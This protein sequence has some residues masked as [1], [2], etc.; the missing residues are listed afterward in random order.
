[1]AS[2]FL[3]KFLQQPYL[4]LRTIN[5][6]A[7]ITKSSLSGVYLRVCLF[8]EVIL[9]LLFNFLMYYVCLFFFFQPRSRYME[10]PGPGI[11]SEW[12]RFCSCSNA[13]SWTH[14]TELGI[15]PAMPQRPARSWSHCATTG[16]P[17]CLISWLTFI[18]TGTEV[19]NQ[20][21]PDRL[22]PIPLF[23]RWVIRPQGQ[24][25]FQ[26]M[27][28]NAKAGLRAAAW[29]PVPHFLHP[30]SERTEPEKKEHQRTMLLVVISEPSDG[31]SVMLVG[32]PQKGK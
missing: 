24:E 20:V 6:N 12:H 21:R 8:R 17:Y 28:H 32:T 7:Q 4:N 10:V 9:A 14:C 31:G 1:M 29:L 16:T 18:K 26:V 15:K 22:F 23:D 19:W 27:Q 11:E 2:S 30:T 13:G 25:W 5:A 3:T